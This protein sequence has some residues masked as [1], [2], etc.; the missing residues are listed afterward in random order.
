MNF[1]ETPG[2]DSR[3]A[4]CNAGWK[5]RA[6]NALRLPSLPVRNSPPISKPF[7]LQERSSAFWELGLDSFF[8]CLDQVDKRLDVF[9]TGET[10]LYFALFEPGFD[11]ITVV[12]SIKDEIAEGSFFCLGFLHVFTDPIAY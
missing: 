11:F 1:M 5:R 10:T 12:A 3:R 6:S 2:L 8:V 9:T 4:I 7:W